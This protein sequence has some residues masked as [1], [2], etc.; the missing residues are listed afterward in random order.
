M[1]KEK[2]YG[3]VIL[4]H[5]SRAEDA[6]KVLSELLEQVQKSSPGKVVVA[7]M[8]L[9]KPDLFEA[10]EELVAYGCENILIAPLFFYK[11]AHMLE[12]IP[13]MINTLRLKHPG[14]HIDI[15]ENIGPDPRV[16][17][18]LLERIWGKVKVDGYSEDQVAAGKL[19][20]K[21][22]F[23]IISGLL[24]K[25]GF[26]D[27]Q[28][29]VVRRIVHSLGDTEIS[30]MVDFSRDAVERGIKAIRSGSDIIVDVNMVAAGI[31]KTYLNK[32][33][34]KLL[35]K[36]SEKHIS[37]IASLEK[38]TRARVAISRCLEGSRSP[39]VVIGN[40]PTALFEVL[41]LCEKGT[42][43][44]SLV[45]GMPVGF[46]GAAESKEELRKSG[47]PFITL[48]GTRG[49]SSAAVAAMNALMKLSVNE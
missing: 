45:I 39:V 19:I 14:S 6:N 16:G 25:N 2:E 24:H 28:N 21:Q 18:I 38:T 41:E 46:V 31:N 1:I 43:K 30:K 15:T 27:E 4:G 9:S 36:I 32:F 48:R 17:S 49:G 26:S 34:C 35:C 8:Q 29:E 12:D 20:E 44:P 5:G 37:S 10:V 40:A 11:G 47:I 22:S 3:I 7:S 23:E 42:V 13:E 33:K